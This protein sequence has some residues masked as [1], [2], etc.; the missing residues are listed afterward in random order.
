MQVYIILLLYT[1]RTKHVTKMWI[2]FIFIFSRR[3]KY[4]QQNTTQKAD[5]YYIY[6]CMRAEGK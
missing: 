1:K 6:K 4:Y 2:L 3:A 5:I